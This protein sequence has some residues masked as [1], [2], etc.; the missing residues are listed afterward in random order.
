MS[1]L[2]VPT[3]VMVYHGEYT[4]GEVEVF[5]E[6]NQTFIQF[7]NNE[8][9]INHISSP[10]ERCLP[11]S[12][13]Q[14]ISPFS[15]KCKLKSKP[16]V[17]DQSPLNLLYSACFNE[18]KTA[19]VL[20]GNE[21]LH[22]VAMPSKQNSFPSFWCCS[23][24]IGLYGASLGML[25]QRCLAIAFDLDETLIVANTMK[26]FED[27]IDVLQRRISYENDPVRVSGMTAELKRYLEDRMILKQYS[28]SDFVMDDGKFCRVQPEAVPRLS[29]NHEQV[30]RPVIRLHDKNIV[31]TRINPEIR[32]TSVL[33]RLRPAWDFFRS[34]LT[35]KGRKR[36]EVYVCTMAER[37]YALEMWRLL[38][39]E[40]QLIDPSKLLSRVVCVKSGKYLN[41]LVLLCFL[42]IVSISCRKSLVNVFQ[43]SI[44]DPK[45]AMVVDDRLNVWED[46]DQFRVHVV[47]A[48]AP[49]YAPQAE[50]A[51]GLA[52][53]CL[54]RNFVS[55]IRTRFFREFDE[56]LSQRVSELCFE[57]EVANLHFSPDVRNC[58]LEDHG[59]VPNGNRDFPVPEGMTGPEVGRRLNEPDGN[60]NVDS[61][62]P[63]LT[64]TALRPEVS[65]HAS[66]GILGPAIISRPL[67][68]LQ[69][70]L[71]PGASVRRE[72]VP[73]E[74]GR[75]LSPYH[76]SNITEQNFGVPP[77]IPIPPSQQ[78]APSIS[79]LVQS[80]GGWLEEEES[81]IVQHNNRV[82]GSN[83]L[84]TELTSMSNR[85]LQA[86]E[87]GKVTLLP[88]SISIGVVQEIGRKCGSKVELK[89]IV[90]TSKDLHFTVEVLFD[91]EKIGVGISKTKRDAQ[92]QAAESALRGLAEKYVAYIGPDTGAMSTHFDKLSHRDEDGFLWDDVS[93]GLDAVPRN[94]MLPN[95]SISEAGNTLITLKSMGDAEAEK[96]IKSPRL[97]ETVTAKRFKDGNSRGL[98]VSSSEYHKSGSAVS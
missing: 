37:D 18:L 75:F 31:L 78:T 4:L 68:P 9:R 72:F 80:H 57:D 45:M 36:F 48:F 46:K 16:I 55:N 15:V 53:L 76:G 81:S 32:D 69:K 97:F 12:I 59:S 74:L 51:N 20:L 23:V 79:P 25:N 52:V 19:V 17:S 84:S 7:P 49:Y 87:G 26:S 35:A 2:G 92:Q 39:T 11:L 3:S 77:L 65:Q 1:D 86:T 22:L 67:L 50:T 43:E 63:F 41:A 73:S 33:V 85:D 34:Y 94:D 91:G 28:E 90:S 56:N 82:P 47:P 96:Q 44:C 54:A 89:S 61:A 40:A 70:P 29:N 38:D 5:P 88:P 62:T 60:C 21:E 13:I 66:P 83:G 64:N 8:I 30:F 24:P 71:L 14:T 10:S 27:R 58:M 98:Q 95:V 93:P 42:A 6:K